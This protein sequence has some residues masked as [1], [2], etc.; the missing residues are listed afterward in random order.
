MGQQLW[1]FMSLKTLHGSLKIIL[2]GVSLIV[3][4]ISLLRLLMP[5]NQALEPCFPCLQT[6]LEFRYEGPRQF[7][8]Q[9]P[10]LSSRVYID[11]SQVDLLGLTCITCLLEEDN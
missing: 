4:L 5:L 7:H 2:H 9:I 11:E 1:V 6:L 10:T 8:H 3:L